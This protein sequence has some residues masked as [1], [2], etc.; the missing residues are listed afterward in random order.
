METEKKYKL[1]IEVPQGQIAKINKQADGN[2]L[3]TF[4]EIEYWKNITTFTDACLYLKRNGLCQNLLDEA[5]KAPANSYLKT[6]AKYRI[7]VAALTNNE[8]RHLTTSEGWFPIIQFCEPGKEKGCLG[9]EI[10]GTIESEGQKFTVVGGYA[11]NSAHMGLDYFDSFYGI[12]VSDAFV[13]FLLISKYEIAQH[14]SKYFGRL[15]FE[16]YYGGVNCDWK[17]IN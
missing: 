16:V 6:L 13:S 12:S 10:I 4:E 2:I 8:K 9:N 3:V 7:I 5:L 1:T 14:I 17:W 11:G 15:L